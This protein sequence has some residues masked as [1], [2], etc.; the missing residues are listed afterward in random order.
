MNPIPPSMDELM[1]LVAE[2]DDPSA[3]ETFGKRYP[4]YRNELGHR[5][6]LVRGLKGSRPTQTP[7]P[8]IPA[9]ELRPEPRPSV[10]RWVAVAACS[11]V[12]LGVA[13]GSYVAI[14][15]WNPERNPAPTVSSVAAPPSSIPSVG[16]FEPQSKSIP[17]VPSEP[18]PNEPTPKQ[19]VPVYAQ[20]ISLK[21]EG[22]SLLQAISSVVRLSRLKVEYAPGMPDIQVSIEYANMS[23]MDIL[24]DMGKTFGFTPFEQE[25][26]TVLLIPATD[27][28]VHDAPSR[29]N[30]SSQT[31]PSAQ[32]QAPA[33]STNGF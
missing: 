21:L 24:R 22:V 3:L 31:P 10:Q 9:F 19:E 5:L 13:F 17:N 33:P 14:K 25:P 29:E 30:A 4:E 12:L 16:S 18:S 7:D 20:P 15:R 26:G 28:S 23:G 2:Q 11:V 1:W 32:P 6:Q 8:Q 27:P